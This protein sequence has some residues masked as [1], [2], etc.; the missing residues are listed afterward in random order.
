MAAGPALLPGDPAGRE[1]HTAEHPCVAHEIEVVFHRRLR[2]PGGGRFLE[3]PNDVGLGYVSRAVGPDCHHVVAAG[4]RHDHK[5]TGQERP[6]RGVVAAVIDLPHLAAR[7]RVV[8]DRRHGR[9]AHEERPAGLHDHRGRAVSLLHVAVIGAVVDGAI[10]LPERLAGGLFEGHDILVVEAVEVDEEPV[11]PGDRRGAGATVVVAG[12]VLPAPED[13]A[14]GR[15]EAGG[16]CTAEVDEEL[17]VGKHGRRARGAV[18]GVAE[19]GLR[20]LEHSHVVN[21]PA[22]V[23]VDTHGREPRAVFG[24]VG[25]PDPSVGSDGRCPG[26]AGDRRLPA[27]VLGLA[28]RK[29]QGRGW[30]AAVRRGPTELVPVGGRGGPCVGHHRHRHAPEPEGAVL[31]RGRQHVAVG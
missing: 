30:G 31:R 19:G 17:A 7:R 20:D 27:D 6:G 3:F 21:D 28:P 16:S 22:S 24:G 1:L 9:R 18:V 2:G 10:G 13:L 26:L 29:R 5:P 8:G 12:K 25:E 4:G 11:L 14:G 15:I 23:G